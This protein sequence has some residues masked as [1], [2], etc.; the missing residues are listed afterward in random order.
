MVLVGDESVGEYGD[1][2][3]MLVKGGEVEELGKGRGPLEGE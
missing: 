3:G 2:R 1:L